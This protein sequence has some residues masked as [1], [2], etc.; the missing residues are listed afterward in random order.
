MIWTEDRARLEVMGRAAG[1][2]ELCGRSGQ[3]LNF[4]H[5]VRRSQGG[6]WTPWNGAA[7]C[8]S[9]TTGCHGWLTHQ[10]VAATVLGWEVHG[11]QDPR[12]VPIWLRHDLCPDGGWVLLLD[13]GHDGDDDGG[14][15]LV[16]SVD[17]AEYGLPVRP[18]LPTWAVAA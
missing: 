11:S 8:G 7:G 10:P 13:P 9:G 17:A 2:C 18:Q 14:P 6:L 12:D 3:V 16:V 1:R 15:H 5:R 4:C